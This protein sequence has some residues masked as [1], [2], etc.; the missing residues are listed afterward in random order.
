MQLNKAFDNGQAKASTAV[1][2]ATGL[3]FKTLKDRF[4]LCFRDTAALVLDVKGDVV[5]FPVTVERDFCPFV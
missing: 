4:L 5:F 1:T 2:G 3:A